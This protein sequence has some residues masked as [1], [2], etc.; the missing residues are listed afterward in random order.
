MTVS[1]QP[2][3][4]TASPGWK[5]L[6]E[7][8]GEGV[9]LAVDFAAS[10]RPESTFTELA[11]LLDPRLPMWETRQPAPDDA[12]LFHG[13]DFVAHW[14]QA[15]RTAGRPVRAVLGYCVGGLYAA[16]LAQHVST[17]Q[18]T[19]PLVLLL[20]PEPPTVP[21]MTA[22]FR[23][24][25]SRLSSV[26]TAQ[27]T[28]LA[29]AA[30]EEAAHD[31]TAFPD[32]GAGLVKIFDDIARAAFDRAGLP[33]ELADELST[34]YG[35]FVSYIAAASAFDPAPL[36]TTAT[37]VTSTGADPHA[38]HAGHRLRVDVAHDDILRSTLTADLVSGLLLQPP[39]APRDTVGGHRSSGK[40]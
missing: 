28:D 36:W 38:R 34:A 27:E 7:G 22:D 15:V 9:V 1:Q 35:A 30:A 13:E 21:G 11:G 3:T 19:A 5:V 24:A 32:L 37:A 33:A 18:D 40:G 31:F 8:D 2:L 10:G 14:A 26:L 16:R 29:A 12:R 20:D 39:S 4:T 6:D 25:I 23:A 17:W